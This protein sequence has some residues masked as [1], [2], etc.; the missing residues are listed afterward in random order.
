MR[1][2]GTT[3]I[4]PANAEQPTWESASSDSTMKGETAY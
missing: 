2:K 1:I 4:G 3:G